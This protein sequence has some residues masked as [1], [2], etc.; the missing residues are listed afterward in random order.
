MHTGRVSPAD[1]LKPTSN[2]TRPHV[3]KSRVIDHLKVVELALEISSD[4]LK[5]LRILLGVLC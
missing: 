4:S 5:V 3:K 2:P 1:L